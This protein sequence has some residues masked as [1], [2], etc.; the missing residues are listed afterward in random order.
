MSDA[1]KQR[2]RRLGD[3][4]RPSSAATIVEQARGLEVVAL[5]VA[6]IAPDPEQVRFLPRPSDVLGAAASG[7]ADAQALLEEL[8]ALGQ[9]LAQQ[10]IHPVVVYPIVDLDPEYPEAEWRLLSGERRWRAAVLTEL[11]TLQAVQ[12][13]RRPSTTE[14]LVFQ[15]V[16]NEAR[17]ALSDLDRAETA[18]RLKASLEAD[19]GGMV[20]WSVVEQRLNLSEARRMQL[21]RLYDRLPRSAHSLVRAYRWSERTLRPLHMALHAKALDEAAALAVLDDLHLRVQRGDEISAALVGKLIAARQVSAPDS[22]QWLTETRARV[23]Q[24]TAESRR[25][26]PDPSI[27]LSQEDQS[28]LRQDV[29]ALRQALGDVLELLGGA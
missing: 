15:Y 7:D 24:M 4:A 11:P 29:A 25:L 2:M 5:P 1:F 12:L 27:H 17:A 3:T 19:G 9:S 18:L 10:Q 21:L 23:Q 28:A 16:E 20:P 22:A 8:R 13:P 14:R 6:S 26:V